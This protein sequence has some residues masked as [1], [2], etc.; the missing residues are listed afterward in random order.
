MTIFPLDAKIGTQDAHPL[1]NPCRTL[2][3]ERKVKEE[4]VESSADVGILPIEE[5]TDPSVPRANL[6]SACL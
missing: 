3:Y 1:V 6:V 4:P 2:Q 5:D